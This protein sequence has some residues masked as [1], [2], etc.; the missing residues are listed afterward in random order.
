MSSK[1]SI[2]LAPSL[3][4]V[5]HCYC[6]N[7]SMSL[8]AHTHYEKGMT[9][10]C[11]SIKYDLYLL[12]NLVSSFRAQFFT[13]ISCFNLQYSSAR[14]SNS[15]PKI[16]KDASFNST[17][18]FSTWQAFSSDSSFPLQARCKKNS[19]LNS[20]IVVSIIFL[21]AWIGKWWFKFQNTSE[22]E[23]PFWKALSPHCYSEALWI[24]M[25]LHFKN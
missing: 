15:F 10:C 17:D 1:R 18:C 22:S 2:Q 19:V 25:A 12:L 8:W 20:V 23:L 3:L 16:S 14:A 11:P 9:G 6:P 7:A 24:I 13:S 21:K 5:Q 4:Y